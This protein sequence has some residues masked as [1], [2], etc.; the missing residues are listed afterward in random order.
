MNAQQEPTVSNNKKSGP[1]PRYEAVG[2]KKFRCAKCGDVKALSLRHGTVC[3]KCHN[4]QS[5][6]TTERALRFKYSMKR[7][8]ARRRGIEFDLTFDDYKSLYEHQH[9]RDGYTGEQ[10]NLAFGHGKS[11]ATVSLDRVDNNAGYTRD[12]I[13]FCTLRSNARKGNRP[14]ATFV[15]QLAFEFSEPAVEVR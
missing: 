5:V 11:G 1:K 14:L 3:T 13:L 15:R 10:L 4:H 8:V 12:N 6:S 7:S 2:T 9:S